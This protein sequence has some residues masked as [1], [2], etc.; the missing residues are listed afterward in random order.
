MI[1]LDYNKLTASLDALL[2]TEL[3]NDPNFRATVRNDL[4]DMVDE[5][6]RINR[7]DRANAPVQYAWGWP[8][9][10]T[11]HGEFDTVEL[12]I[13]DARQVAKDNDIG[14]KTVWV[15]PIERFEISAKSIGDT[16]VEQIECDAFDFAGEYADGWPFLNSEQIEGLGNVIIGEI[17]AVADND[18]RF[19]SVSYDK[20][21]IYNLT[22]GEIAT[23]EDL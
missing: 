5:I 16:V 17:N 14:M 21:T 1:H 8:N 9:R 7:E 22:T 4:M 20:G 11:V 13:A 18:P 12:A 10:H 2:K 19:W 3:I 6:D 15:G 23:V